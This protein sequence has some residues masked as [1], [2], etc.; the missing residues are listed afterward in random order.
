MRPTSPIS[1]VVAIPGDGIY[2]MKRIS[3][4]VWYVASDCLEVPRVV[5]A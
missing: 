2:A 5:E 4:A 1:I 3:L